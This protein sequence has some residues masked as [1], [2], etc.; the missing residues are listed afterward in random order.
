MPKQLLFIRKVGKTIKVE[1][2]QGIFLASIDSFDINFFN[3]V[4]LEELDRI[5]SIAQ[6]LEFHIENTTEE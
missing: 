4:T 1:N 3:S 2:Q 5:N 6:D